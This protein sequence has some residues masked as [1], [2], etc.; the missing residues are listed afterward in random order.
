MMAAITITGATFALAMTSASWFGNCDSASDALIM[1]APMK[2]MKI[3]PL[4]TA[5]VRTDMTNFRAFISRRVRR[6]AD[7][8]DILQEVFIRI[9]R[10]VNSVRNTERLPA[11]IFQLTRNA[12]ADHFRI[13]KGQSKAVRED[14]DPVAPTDSAGEERQAL[15]ELSECIQPMVAGLPPIYRKAIEL[16]D[17]NGLTQIEAAQRSGLSFSGMKSRVQRANVS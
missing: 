16:T 11:W 3:M 5:V 4:V 1:S 2:I 8:E 10:S 12:I 6:A 17:L 13:G 14:V 7:V 15:K 9:H